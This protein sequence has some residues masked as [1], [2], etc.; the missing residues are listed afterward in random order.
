MRIFPACANQLNGR[1]EVIDVSTAV[2]PM[3]QEIYFATS[4]ETAKSLSLNFMN[5]VMHKGIGLD[6]ELL[7]GRFRATI[8]RLAELSWR[9]ASA[10]CRHGW[11]RMPGEFM[12]ESPYFAEDIDH[13]AEWRL[14]AQSP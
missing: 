13:P 11:D 8:P 4:V 1:G 2:I 7:L 5:P 3:A 14:A 6:S 12:S 9:D 10:L